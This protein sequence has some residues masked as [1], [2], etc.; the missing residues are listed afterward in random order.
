[1]ADQPSSLVTIG[2]CLGKKRL[3]RRIRVRRTDREKV[4][5]R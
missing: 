3:A 1:M 4:K 5:K 2:G